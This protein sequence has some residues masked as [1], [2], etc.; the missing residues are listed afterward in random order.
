MS[1]HPSL[2]VDSAV[3]Q[4]R[5]VLTRIERIKDLMKKGLWGED[6]PVTAL[7]KT[8]IVRIKTGKSKKKEEAATAATAPAAGEAKKAPKS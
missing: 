7:P 8:K 1:L 5:T 2:R 6:R 3:T 4:Q